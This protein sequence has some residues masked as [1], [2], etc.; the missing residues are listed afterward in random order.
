MASH[1]DQVKS[2]LEALQTLLNMFRIERFIYLADRSR[3]SVCSSTRR[4][5]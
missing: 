4:S 1:P 3:R 5:T 2:A